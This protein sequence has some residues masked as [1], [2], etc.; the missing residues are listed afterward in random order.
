MSVG[1]VLGTKEAS[2]LEFW[3]GIHESSS[4][5]LD[6]LVTVETLVPES[7]EMV[8]FYGVVDH[9]AKKFEG[10]QFDTDTSLA[11]HGILPVTLSHAAHVVVTRI[12]P[13]K[14]I[15]PHPGSEVFRA[16]GKSA[17][18][19]LYFDRMEHK[20]PVGFNKS[21]EPFYI[22]FSFLNGEKGAHVS[23]S[24]ISGIAT[25]TTFAMFLLY[26]IFRGKTHAKE[27]SS[28]NHAIVFNVKGEDLLFLDQRN[29]KFEEKE[30]ENYE[31]LKLPA[32]PF[33]S[34]SFHAPP[35]PNEELVVP[36]TM[37]RTE[38]VKPFFWTLRQVAR[39]RLI[40]FFFEEGGEDLGT[41]EHAISVLSDK[42]LTLASDSKGD[43][44]P[45]QSPS[46]RPLTS[47]EDLLTDLRDQPESWYGASQVASQTQ[48]ALFRRLSQ[49]A[50]QGRGLIRPLPAGTKAGGFQL[51]WRQKQITVIDLH[52]LQSGAK[53]FVVGSIL[54]KILEEKEKTGSSEPRVFVVVDELNK[55]A[56]R[57]GWSPIK[58]RL[59]DI[60]ERGRSLGIILIGAQQTAS[61]VEARI[62][63]NAA[64][65]VVGRLDPAE[66]G[67][68]EY[69]FL[70][71][72]FRKRALMLSPGSMIISQPDVPTP[73][74]AQIPYPV[75]ATRPE[76][77]A[78]PED[79]FEKLFP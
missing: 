24:G 50:Q 16:H 35:K 56:P 7:G 58:S 23:I 36:A 5:Q 77:A 38:N 11:V 60:A 21:R 26:S 30:K 65:K 74:I 59:L 69:D 51:D 6:D 62:F 67:H 12:E 47:L 41:L 79:L 57:E 32:L 34:V 25:K 4:L 8:T 19:G 78:V 39:E 3:V 10:T 64:I 20:I 53:M 70:T 33:D 14:Y 66:A 37:R 17:E 49:A 45:L 54:K 43:E 55:Y 73:V 75:W 42:L 29:S 61:Q 22:N 63:A 9:V 76:E 71:S 28:N 1:L 31:L 46:G 48:R 15:P 52:T 68:P 18:R 27:I 13:Q 40:G 72:T 2:P 44:A